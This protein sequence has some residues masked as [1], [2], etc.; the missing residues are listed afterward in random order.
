[1]AAI[2]LTEENDAFTPTMLTALSNHVTKVLPSY[3][4]PKFIRVKTSF[5][6]TSTFKQQKVALVNE[7]FDVSQIHEPLFYLNSSMHTYLPLDQTIFS[8]I[9]GRKMSF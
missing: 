4:Q 7:G 8:Q 3:A 6:M 2:T 9:M 5:D 1:M